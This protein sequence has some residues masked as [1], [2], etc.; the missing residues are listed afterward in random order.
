MA[1]VVAWGR[2]VFVG[3]TGVDLAVCVVCG[4]G[5]PDLAAVDALAR[6]Q[7]AARR[8]GGHVRLSEVSR[9]LA[10]LLDLAG[11]GREVGWEA[12]GGEEVGV[13]EGVEPGDPVA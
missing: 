12:E 9:D 2:L 1:A 4:P 7:L 6:V 10:Q 13:E 3:P 8:L 11:L 5:P